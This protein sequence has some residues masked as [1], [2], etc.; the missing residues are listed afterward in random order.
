MTE[1]W[2][3]RS[4]KAKAAII[5]GAVVLVIAAIASNGNNGSKSGDKQGGGAS[6]QA[7]STQQVTEQQTA[8]TGSAVRAHDSL[9]GF[10][11]TDAAWDAN[12]RADDRFLEGSVYDPDPSL[13]RGGDQRFDAR[14]YAVIHLDGRIF[15]YEMRFPPGTS[16]NEAKKD[17]LT[18]EF[19]GDAKIAW[20]KRR[21]TC[22]QMLVRRK[23]IEQLTG[24]AALVAFSSGAAGDRYDARD[25]WNAILIS[26]GKNT[27][28][29]C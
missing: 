18:T 14:Y 22:A 2:Q 10:A 15:S 21:D 5:A 17:V 11:A 23:T 3:R 28:L 8:E 6:S 25:V 19:P 27:S 24:D 4:R 16:A 13:A 20:F 1:F 12:H 29:G 26:V 9:T 7:V